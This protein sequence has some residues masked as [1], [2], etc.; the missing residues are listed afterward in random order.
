MPG[1]RSDFAGIRIL[2][3]AADAVTTGGPLSFSP[4]IGH[5]AN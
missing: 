1:S 5:N 4:A 3:G 2:R